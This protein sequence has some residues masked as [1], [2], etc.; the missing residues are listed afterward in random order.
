[1]VPDFSVYG[2]LALLLWACGEAEHHGRECVVEQNSS[3][4]GSQEA[5]RKS[6][7]GL[8]QGLLFKATPPVTYF[9]Q[10]GPTSHSSLISQIIYLNFES[11]NGLNY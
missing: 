6:W 9:L 2:G 8:E 4:H 7:K 1:M 10:P 3:H 11:I 5:E